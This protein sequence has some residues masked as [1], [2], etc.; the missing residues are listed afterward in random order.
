LRGTIVALAV[1]LSAS[2]SNTQDAIAPPTPHAASAEVR[3]QENQQTTAVENPGRRE[4][5]SGPKSDWGAA[6]G[7]GSEAS[8]EERAT[9]SV[10]SQIGG[11]PSITTSDLSL[12]TAHAD[13]VPYQGSFNSRQTD[14]PN[15]GRPIKLTAAQH[16]YNGR[17]A[18]DESP[19]HDR[20]GTKSN[21]RASIALQHPFV[22]PRGPG[23]L[24]AALVFQKSTPK[25]SS[26][27]PSTASG[28]A[29]RTSSYKMQRIAL[30]N[31][32]E[33]DSEHLHRIHRIRNNSDTKTA[34]RN[35]RASRITPWGPS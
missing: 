30:S 7:R 15:H 18:S 26:A 5:N 13:N 24:L 21:R 1:S 23:D 29:G 12:A 2:Q 35:I 19:S 33:A 4:A 22:L 10:W 28:A 17:I 20:R 27:P 31:R 25:M 32:A 8:V 9:K 34:V 3:P 14:G 6:S 11:W 16:K